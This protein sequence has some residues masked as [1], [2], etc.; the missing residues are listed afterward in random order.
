MRSLAIALDQSP[1]TPGHVLGQAVGTL[2]R[3]LRRKD[4]TFPTVAARL[5]PKAE[6][7]TASFAR[8]TGTTSRH[9]RTTRKTTRAH[10]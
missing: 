2:G 8:S 7:F 5:E 3:G 6:A 9:R 4:Q 1:D 10:P